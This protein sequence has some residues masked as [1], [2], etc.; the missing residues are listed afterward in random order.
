[1]GESNEITWSLVKTSRGKV[2]SR[3]INLDSLVD[4]KSEKQIL[5]KRGNK[6]WVIS[7]TIYDDNSYKACLVVD[8]NSTE[9]SSLTVIKNNGSLSLFSVLGFTITFYIKKNI[10]YILANDIYDIYE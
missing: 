9:D 2:N 8:E 10:L 3:Y 5:V 6:E 4:E 1:M 7:I